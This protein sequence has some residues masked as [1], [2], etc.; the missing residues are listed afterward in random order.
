[1]KKKA[2]GVKAPTIRDVARLSGVSHT[3]VSFVIN[4]V[5]G[6]SISEETRAR[7][8]EAV[9]LLDYH[10]SEA[11]RSLNRRTSTLI[12]FA[13]PESENAHYQE[14]A[15][16]IE[17]YVEEHNFGLFRVLTHFE[18]AREQR[19]FT[20]LKQKRYD[21]LI[22]IPASGSRLNEE[23]NH[24]FDQGYPV[25]TLGVMH[26]RVDNVQAE[27]E[28][29]EREIIQH[30][31]EL[32]HRR[33][34][35]IHGVAD[36]TIFDYRLDACVRAQ[37]KLGL[38]VRDEW[39]HRCGPTVA[40]GYNAAKMLFE[41]RSK[42]DCPTA[43]VVVNDLLASAVVAALSSLGLRIPQDVSI[44]TFDNTNLAQYTVFPPLTSVDY[45]AYE[46]GRQ[47]A[48]LLIARLAQRDRPRVHLEMRARLI[49]R[50]STGP[51]AS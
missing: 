25:V 14:I 40:D 16:G 30:L 18:D 7:V 19:C 3:T 42:K 45:Q 8:L 1:M 38:T 32:G 49:V 26:S 35:Y 33:I 44:A 2:P 39:I 51:A 24:L 50:Q 41:G 28:R 11:A 23:L 46:M 43:L 29:G 36:H 34:G 47:A 17:R 20:W 37:Q 15:I 31:F 48:E 10:P 5:A 12:G 27:L 9:K 4:D 21:G 6:E 13:L 22:L